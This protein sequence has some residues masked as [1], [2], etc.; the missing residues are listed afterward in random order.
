M[1]EFVE[2]K[3]VILR[4][5]SK[6]K[7]RKEYKGFCGV[8]KV[9]TTPEMKDWEI[10]VDGHYSPEKFCKWLAAKYLFDDKCELFCSLKCCRYGCGHI[11]M[12]GDGNHRMCV[13]KQLG[14]SVEVRMEESNALCPICE[15][16][17]QS[18]REQSIFLRL[19]LRKSK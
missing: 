2:A 13:L 19:I 18:K 9:T 1:K 4:N 5:M 16:S 11:T 14:E 15:E 6:R 12:A 7:C 10:F 3:D 17:Q 8:S